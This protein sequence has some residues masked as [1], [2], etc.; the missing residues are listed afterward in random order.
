MLVLSAVLSAA[1][2][3]GNGTPGDTT[4]GTTGSTDNP[5][6]ST[7]DSSS[8][9]KDPS[10]DP[11]ELFDTPES[12]TISKT[13]YS[14][15]V[16]IS[17]SKN[18]K[19]GALDIEKAQYISMYLADKLGVSPTLTT[20]FARV[21]DSEK[22]EI[23]VGATD[24]PETD[25]LIASMSYGDYAVRGVG[26]KIIVMAFSEEGYE[27]AIEHLTT[28][29]N[30]GLNKKEKT[31]T[32][33]T[34][35]LNVTKSCHAQLAA[36]PTYSGG[37]FFASYDA[38]RVTAS[39]DCDEII[40]NSTNS[41]EFAEYL[42]KLEENGYTQ[43]SYNEMAG[44]K[45][46]IYTNDS[47]TVNVG[48]YQNVNEARLL[49]EPKGALPMLE[50]DNN[51]TKK[52]TSQITLIGGQVEKIGSTLGVLIRLEDGRFIVVDGGAGD[53]AFVQSFIKTVKKQSVS[54]NPV[55]AAWIITHTH[56]DHTRLLYSGYKE[57]KN[58]GITVEAIMTNELSRY[59]VDRAIAYDIVANQP[60][61]Y[62]FPEDDY[63]YA[64]KGIIET[65][66]PYLEADLYKPHIGQVF[67]IS[68]CKIEVVY[69]L[70][71][72]APNICNT[73]NTTSVVMKMTF[74]DSA[75]GKVT[76]FLSTGDASGFSM[77]VANEFFGDYLKSDILTIAHHGAMTWGDDSSM[78]AAY[79]KIDAAL[80]LWPTDD[81]YYDAS[82]V[83]TQNKPLFSNPGFKESYTMGKVGEG[84]IVPLP[85]VV[86][87]VQKGKLY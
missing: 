23:I 69:T 19:S 58:A 36:L 65:V 67:N 70:E 12:Y 52:T 33:N 87:N 45:F 35:E 72:Y 39:T 38:G 77:K 34:A 44:N 71:G 40:I 47:Y 22:F 56:G 16:E 54:A 50:S 75:S 84:V 20:D 80:L 24:H 61:I 85:Y 82:V 21:E 37:K 57:I 49:I 83:A 53:S 66:A 28:V 73:Q 86:G 46:A 48:Y 42:T 7:S 68:N 1:V 76:T 31:I 3:C 59:E 74:T 17:R 30:N 32:L 9:A 4:A 64:I 13:D 62:E 15:N 41:T 11:D 25:A 78:V 2:S 43:Y 10:V 6:A 26:N 79:K 55:I 18:S 60:N 8:G 29:I 51:T 81:R 14:L 5:L 27:K 63:G